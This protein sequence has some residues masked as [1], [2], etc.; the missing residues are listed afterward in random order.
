MIRQTFPYLNLTG[1]KFYNLHGD[2]I[3]SLNAPNSSVEPGGIIF[4]NTEQ[5]NKINLP[6][7]Y[8]STKTKFVSNATYM[9]PYDCNQFRLRCFDTPDILQGGYESPTL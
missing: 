8:G 1:R 9:S 7:I 2:E 3:T 5:R 6:T 4:S